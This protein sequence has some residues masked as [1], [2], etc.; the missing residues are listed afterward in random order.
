[1]LCNSLEKK[2]GQGLAGEEQYIIYLI[3]LLH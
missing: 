2:A 3:S 1:M